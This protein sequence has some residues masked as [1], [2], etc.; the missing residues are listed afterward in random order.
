MRYERR[1]KFSFWY[2]SVGRLAL[3]SGVDFAIFSVLG[4]TGVCSESVIVLSIYGNTAEG[5][6]DIF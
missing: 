3:P 2:E 5:I 4:L 1:Y 6:R